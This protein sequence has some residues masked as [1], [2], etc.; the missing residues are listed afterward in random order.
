[1]TVS[2]RKASRLIEQ[3]IAAHV[4]RCA[5]RKDILELPDPRLCVVA[6][7][8]VVLRSGRGTIA[9]LRPVATEDG[10]TRFVPEAAK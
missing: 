5:A 10:R 4:G 7:G 1:M 3:A 8:I 9:R 2:R 6:D